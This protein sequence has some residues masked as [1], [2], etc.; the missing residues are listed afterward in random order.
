MRRKNTRCEQCGAFVLWAGSVYG[1]RPRG[2]SSGPWLIELLC[3]M[4]R[5][6]MYACGLWDIKEGYRLRAGRGVER[7]SLSDLNAGL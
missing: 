1:Y 3:E 4:C 6:S 7:V 2:V 5:E